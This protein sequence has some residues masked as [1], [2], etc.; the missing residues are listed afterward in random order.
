MGKSDELEATCLIRKQKLEYD[1]NLNAKL[2]KMSVHM[3]AI[4]MYNFIT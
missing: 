2:Y 1:S 4:N 3:H